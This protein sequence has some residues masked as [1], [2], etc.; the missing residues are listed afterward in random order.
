MLTPAIL[1]PNLSNMLALASLSPNL[2][3][4]LKLT[5]L[6]SPNLSNLYTL[7]LTSLSYFIV[8]L[9]SFGDWYDA[10]KVIVEESRLELLL[11]VCRACA[12]KSYFTKKRN[13]GYLHYSVTCLD[14]GNEFTFATTPKISRYVKFR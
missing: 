4:M 1:S 11:S 3:N 9:C 10:P 12:G 8:N 7:A 5:V 2:A 6:S 14:C 13:G